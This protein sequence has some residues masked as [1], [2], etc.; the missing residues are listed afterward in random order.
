[1]IKK[2]PIVVNDEIVIKPIMKITLSSDHR[3]IDGAVGAAFMKDLKETLENPIL[4]I[5]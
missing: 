5:L 2:T 3:I 4:A 1:M